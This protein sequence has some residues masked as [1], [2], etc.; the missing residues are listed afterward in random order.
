[1]FQKVTILGNLGADPETR[2][3]AD[4]TAVTNFSVATNEHWTTGDGEKKEKTTWF[5]VSC[6]RRL[7]E[8][9]GEYLSK[10]RIVLIEGTLD[11]DPQTGGPKTFNRQ[12]GTVGTSYQLT[13]HTLKFVGGQDAG[14]AA[15]AASP[16]AQQASRPAGNDDEEDEIP[17]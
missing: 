2:Y 3:M 9:A 16:P 4:G 13:A 1:M 6:W 10:G 8:I 12:D 14:S 15:G 5:R 11:S 17:F 7:G